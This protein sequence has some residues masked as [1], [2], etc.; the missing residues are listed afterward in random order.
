[1]VYYLA[2]DIGASSGRHILGYLD[3]TDKLVL[4]EIYRFPN[5]PITKD[6]N[7]IWDI[8]GLFEEILNG[9]KRAKEI[10]KTP[11]Y[12]G[13]DTWAV[14]YVLLDSDDRRIGDAFCYRDSRC[15]RA[16]SEVHKRI[17]FDELYK[18]TGIQ[19]QL[20]NTV[21]QLFS[22]KKSDR[23][24]F[25]QSMLMLP[26][27]FG[28]L[29]TKVKRQ[30]YTNAT[31]TGLINCRTHT[32]DED[33]INSLGFSKKL[34]GTI[35]NPGT[36]VG[37]FSKAIAEAVGFDAKVILPATHDT[38]SSVL[39]TPIIDVSPY[40][41][42]GTWSLLG[43]ERT[44]ANTYIE[45][46]TYN[47]SNEGS[48]DLKFRFQKNI[49]GLWMIQQVKKEF[50]DKYSFT[51]L[52]A[53][54]QSNPTSLRV[55]VNDGVFL[56]PISMTESIHKAVKEKLTVGETAHCIFASLAEN[57]AQSI[58]QLEM[59]TGE[60]YD[61]LHIMGGGCKNS[62]LNKLTKQCTGKRVFIGPIEST[63]TGNIIMQMI[64]CGNIKNIKE[65]RKIIRRSFDIQEVM[66]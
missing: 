48:F 55:N 60:T 31:S 42:S 21:Y 26:D 63:A 5:S 23:L 22:D 4:E 6:G 62:F 10:G 44:A 38:A 50:G 36:E 11:S 64:G 20:F 43:I 30:E 29:L 14:D 32:W 3:Q 47:Y 54:A 46:Q 25:A 2:I 33:I 35:S 24:N 27:Y 40:I 39:A 58:R 17:G 8:D 59:L 9:L 66:V 18:K 13:I 57:Y 1:M 52:I 41:S 56:S 45:S 15:D 7:L 12:I 28:F 34:F 51:E 49:M 19:F 53:L 37:C 61:T 16:V 65:G